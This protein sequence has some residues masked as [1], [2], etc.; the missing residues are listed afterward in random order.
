[1]RPLRSWSL[2]VAMRWFAKGTDTGAS[3]LPA[4]AGIAI[5]VTALIVIVSVMN[6]FQMGFIDSVLELDSYHLRISQPVELPVQSI[7]A[8]DSIRSVLPFQEMRTMIKTRSG[9][10]VPIKL[11]IVPENPEQLDQALQQRLKVVDGSLSNLEGVIIGNE[12]AR[13]MRVGVGDIIYLLALHSSES[14]GL[15]TNLLQVPVTGVFHS[16][17]YEFDSGLVFTSPSTIMQLADTTT[18]GLGIK[19]HDRY[20][21]IKV[22]NQLVQLGIPVQQI[23]SWR[24]YNKAFFGALRMEKTIMLLLVGIIFLVVGVNIFHA[25]RKI[26]FERMDEIAILKAIGGQVHTVRRIFVLN[27]LIT[28]IGGAVCGLLLGLLISLQVNNIFAL[29]D[30][31]NSLIAAVTGKENFT[32]FSP[33]IF[34]MSEI[35]VRTVFLEIWFITLAGILSAVVAAWISSSRIIN[36]RPAEVLRHE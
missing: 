25:M 12:L 29:L 17:Y 3:F 20:S 6:G 4:A 35:P 13:Q 10:P 11:K 7:A 15:E 8:L 14:T 18:A 23:E 34:Y 33:D 24:S 22:T 5:G 36:F 16:A 27:G 31:L 2:H 32:L 21:D 19:L 1:M 26:I 28:G 30:K 9:S